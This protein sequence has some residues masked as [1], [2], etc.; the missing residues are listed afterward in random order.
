MGTRA[1]ALDTFL[2][3]HRGFFAGFLAWNVRKTWCL[4]GKCV[5][6][7]LAGMMIIIVSAE[8]V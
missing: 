8:D 5:D 4:G 7:K 2:Q 1:Q 3:R 6:E